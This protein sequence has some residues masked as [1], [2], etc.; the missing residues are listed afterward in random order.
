MAQSDLHNLQVQK[1]SQSSPYVSSTTLSTSDVPDVPQ[2][3]RDIHP[4]NHLYIMPWVGKHLRG[5][6]VIDPLF[7]PILPDFMGLGLS[8]G[9][10]KHNLRL[11]AWS[12]DA[13]IWIRPRSALHSSTSTPRRTSSLISM[14]CESS[15]AMT[16]KV[17]ADREDQIRLSCSCDYSKMAVYLPETFTG[18]LIIKDNGFNQEHPTS[19]KY[20]PKVSVRLTTLSEVGP[21]KCLF[22]GDAQEVERYCHAYAQT[23]R[24]SEV[25]LSNGKD[26]LHEVTNCDG[27]GKRRSPRCSE[28]S[29]ACRIAP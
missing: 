12:I 3:I 5:T 7:A 13:D 10:E 20:S 28:L 21:K 1:V 15:S 6:Y 17:H 16:V 23:G 27:R 19:V 22:I 29:P 2:A 4:T 26:G 8:P 11:K 18:P 9:E 14:V 25:N 24:G